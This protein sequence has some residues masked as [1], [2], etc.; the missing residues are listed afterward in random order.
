MELADPLRSYAVLIGSAAY[1][2]SA[3]DDL[4]A[5][6]E[7][8]T[9]LADLLRDP[10]VWGL[11]AERCVLV[12]DPADPATV[13]RAIH[14]AARAAEDTLLVYYAGHG[15]ADETGLLLTLPH[16]V[17]EEPYTAV[18]F[19]ALRREVLR[20]PR[21]TSRIV[22]LDCCYSGRALVGGMSGAAAPVEM[23]EQT[24]I[25]GTYLLTASAATRKALSPPG[26]TYTA[27]T[28]ELIRLLEDGLPG[29]DTL[30]EVGRI[31]EH[32]HAEL[33]AKGRPLP[34]QRISN[35]GRTLAFARNRYGAASS[36]AGTGRGGPPGAG[37]GRSGRPDGSKT[38]ASYAVRG[39]DM[40]LTSLA[41]I[42]A[43]T[44]EE[45]S[46][47]EKLG[48][49][50]RP[51]VLARRAAE[52]RAEG[53]AD[54]ADQ[55]LKM[56]GTL[57]PAQ[58]VAA[59]A[60]VL[61]TEATMD[62]L[63]QVLGS[64]L[65]RGAETVVDCVEAMHA[66][67]NTAPLVEGLMGGS[68]TRPPYEVAELVTTLR[69]RGYPDDATQLVERAA[70]LRRASDELVDLLGALWSAELTADADHVLELATT[71]SPEEALRLADALLGMGR[72]ERA[73]ALYL[74]A[75]ELV[76]RHPPK[77]LGRLLWAMEEMGYG[78]SARELL[79]VALRGP[80]EA[81][82]MAG[83][84]EE[85]WSAG[86]EG[87]AQ[88]VLERVLEVL[89]PPGA[90]DMADSLWADDHVAA[91]LS[92][93]GAAAH[94]SPV[95]DTVG[96]VDALRDMGRPVDANTLL[97]GVADRPGDEVVLFLG[98]L[99]QLH[100]EQDRGR[101]L[102]AV[103]RRP[104]PHRIAVFVGL[105]VRSGVDT[106][107]AMGLLGG[108]EAD[109]L[110]V[111]M[112]LRNE[113]RPDI[114]VE[115]LTFLADFDPELATTRLSL[116]AS[117]QMVPEEAVLAAVLNRAGLL[118]E[119]PT[120]QELREV[121]RHSSLPVD[122]RVYAMAALYLAG[123]GVQVLAA[124]RQSTTGLSLDEITDWLAALHRAGLTDG[125]Q[126]VI[127][128]AGRE[129]PS[130]IASLITALYEAGLNDYAVFALGDSI[131][132]LSGA[133]VAALASPLEDHPL[134]PAAIAQAYFAAKGI[135]IGPADPADA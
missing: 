70:A 3:L 124:L 14:R 117:E 131:H 77:A 20:A 82:R 76:V 15:L 36:A 130:A 56:A 48:L 63:V 7:N 81:E 64:A 111:M 51:A 105:R 134:I 88:A 85:L 69:G 33:R 104:L 127:R 75:A 30:I 54:S 55:L 43:R 90:L 11:P 87:Q 2:A 8:L 97:A 31:Y 37:A 113:Y 16:T 92:L 65:R 10:A 5:V 95:Q 79:A 100:R 52:L 68:A 119:R 60:A 17:P 123:Y 1:R 89:G 109:F 38:L 106:D 42:V 24:R 61:F 108:P 41:D 84:Y 114:L 93:L 74:Q 18:E 71:D 83:L 91:A 110:E 6:A 29:G 45:P 126:A 49:R 57:R 67:D 118:L 4:P 23:A 19:D 99:E 58:E 115:L 129:S 50:G 21:D 59:L 102:T 47:L 96:F 107:L 80:I 26:E 32:L 22:I 44:P 62:G 73:F 46:A 34:Q 120:N 122:A 86:K 98:H 28:G 116:L 66:L 13:L 78:D 135:P 27:F 121:L 25:A 112:E 35:T 12:P 133:Q 103:E 125:A 40:P 132:L 128:D 72:E 94:A 39:V 101:L 9:R 53:D